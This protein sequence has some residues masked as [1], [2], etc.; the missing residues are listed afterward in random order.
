[1]SEPSPLS[2]GLPPPDELFEREPEKKGCGVGRWGC[3]GLVLLLMGGVIFV[4]GSYFT[5]SVL[6]EK[7]ESFEEVAQQVLESDK[8]VFATALDAYRH[9][10]GRYPSTE[11]G[12]EALTEKPTKDPVPSRWYPYL[13][14][15]PKDPWKQPYKYRHPAV[16]SK[17]E[18]DVY[19]V[20]ADGVEGTAD[21]IGNW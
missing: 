7:K 11:Q 6:G 10:A 20:G 14:M 13:P 12:L 18:Y 15:L 2:P 4:G 21:D 16:K 19:S 8:Q 17:K 1:M 5:N 3:V 9:T